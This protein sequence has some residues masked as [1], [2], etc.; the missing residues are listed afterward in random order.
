M[1]TAIFKRQTDDPTFQRR[2]DLIE[3][4]I[5]R[6]ARIQCAKSALALI[7]KVFEVQ[8]KRAGAPAALYHNV[9]G[10]E[11]RGTCAVVEHLASGEK[12]VHPGLPVGLGFID[13]AG[14]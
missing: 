6:S 1:L 3:H 10:P 2:V 7:G 5:T 11:R 9:E 12:T 4:R 8:L 13:E 14:G